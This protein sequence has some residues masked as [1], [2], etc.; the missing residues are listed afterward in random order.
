MFS[1]Q[2]VPVLIDLNIS[3]RVYSAARTSSGSRGYFPP[4]GIP[5]EWTPDIDRYQLGLTMLQVSTGISFDV[6]PEPN[7]NLEDL[8]QVALSEL[9]RGLSDILLKATSSTKQERY[10][11]TSSLRKA[12]AKLHR[13]R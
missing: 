10:G 3:S 5:L 2:G 12:V 7:G 1:V 8:R 6:E 4:D 9:P 13:R 11:S